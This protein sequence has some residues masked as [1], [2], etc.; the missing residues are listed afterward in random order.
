M[1]V[2]REPHRDKTDFVVRSESDGG[3]PGLR[4]DDK[5]RAQSRRDE[6]NDEFGL[7]NDHRVVE[8]PER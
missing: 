2:D 4:F 8:E 5:A 7:P 6:L 1:N 3:C